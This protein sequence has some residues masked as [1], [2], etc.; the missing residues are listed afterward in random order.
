M[1]ANAAKALSLADMVDLTPVPKRAKAIVWGDTWSLYDVVA[2][3]Q[4]IRRRFIF[5]LM[6][7][8][9]L[10]LPPGGGMVNQHDYLNGS[11][12]TTP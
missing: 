7:Q 1:R 12:Y 8:N 2:P 10:G 4:C 9:G 5:I 6:A 3:R 11:L